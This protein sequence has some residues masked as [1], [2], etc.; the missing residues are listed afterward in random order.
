MKTWLTIFSIA[1]TCVARGADP[2]PAAGDPM[3][4]LREL[5]RQMAPVKTVYLEFTQERELKLFKEPLRSEGIL[6]MEKPGQIRWETTSPYQSILLGSLKS[7]AQFEETDGKWQ[8]L[9]LGFPQAL[10][11]AIDQMTMM[12]QGRVDEL[13]RDFDLSATTGRV[14]V[15]TMVPK[16]ATFRGVIAS[17]EVEMAADFST[18]KQVVLKEPSGDLTRIIFKNE[19]RDVKFPERAFDQIQPLPV[20]DLKAAVLHAP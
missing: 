11:R 20:A 1:L 2:A 17:M 4:L 13:A 15:L 3:V 16:D 19:H 14:A 9:K 8:K 12:N 18:T 7:V 10:K 5:Q 6:L